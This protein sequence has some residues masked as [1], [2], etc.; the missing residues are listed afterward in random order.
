MRPRAG[1]LIYVRPFE[2]RTGYAASLNDP[3][4]YSTSG[5]TP[6]HAVEKLM[7][8]V[9]VI[10]RYVGSSFLVSDKPILV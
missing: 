7:E 3:D 8:E 6:Q 1:M 4:G 9:E 5:S 2:N 10:T